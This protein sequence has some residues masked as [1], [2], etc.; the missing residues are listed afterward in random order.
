ML[1][2]RVAVLVVAAKVFNAYR[3]DYLPGTGGAWQV[4]KLTSES[5]DVDPDHDGEWFDLVEAVT[6]VFDFRL[7]RER[8]GIFVT[9]LVV[10][11]FELPQV[12]IDLSWSQVQLLRHLVDFFSVALSGASL[13]LF[14]EHLSEYEDLLGAKS[15][16]LDPFHV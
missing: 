16:L 11:V 9:A 12:L 6:S 14:F 4:H 7:T 8:C 5:F 3:L 13:L 2:G 15:P 1:Q 10:L